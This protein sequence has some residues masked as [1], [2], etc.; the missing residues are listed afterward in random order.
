MLTENKNNDSDTSEQNKNT[1]RPIKA[2]TARPFHTF[3]VTHM[4][5]TEPKEKHIKV[6]VKKGA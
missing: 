1:K 3:N 4:K 2:N 5:Q 6:E